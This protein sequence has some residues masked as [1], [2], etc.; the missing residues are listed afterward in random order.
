VETVAS[1][2]NRKDLIAFAAS[3]GAMLMVG[4]GR[5]SWPR[6]GAAAGLFVLALLSKEVVALGAGLATVVIASVRPSGGEAERRRPVASSDEGPRRRAGV[7]PTT[8]VLVGI[9]LLTAG[10]IAALGK[11][12]AFLF[13]PSAIQDLTEGVCADY[14]DVLVQVG[15]SFV[16]QVSRLLA[17][18][19]LSADYSVE[20]SANPWTARRAWAGLALWVALAVTAVR[21]LARGSPAGVAIAW[22]LLVHLPAS[23]LVP[24]TRFF[25]ADRY[26]YAPSFGA[27]LM[28]AIG[29][30]FAARRAQRKGTTGWSWALPILLVAAATLASVAQGHAWRSDLTLW[31]TSL[32]HQPR[33]TP[34]IHAN[35]GV[36]LAEAGDHRA[37][38]QHFGRAAALQPV[39][40]DYEANLALAWLALED[41]S[42]A[43]YHL[44]RAIERLPWD[45]QLKALR[46]RITRSRGRV[47]PPV[48]PPTGPE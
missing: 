41:T 40:G 32:R 18:V 19:G 34:R 44:A 7:V 16:P 28:V 45:D 4:S 30:E 47:A 48:A 46:D 39:N 22:V 6:W 1:F 25:Q 35:L 5:A 14:A 38:I 10:G 21:F 29:W 43:E 31:A 23:N 12:T 27:C 15:A 3:T 17:P 37:A 26:W 24:L 8:L 42:R 2:A 11:P 36:A 13:R 20:P 9:A 33:G